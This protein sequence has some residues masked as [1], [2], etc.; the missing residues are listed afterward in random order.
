M[1]TR[2]EHVEADAKIDAPIGHRSVH[3]VCAVYCPHC[4]HPFDG[5]LHWGHGNI[6]DAKCGNCD[7]WFKVEQEGSTE[8]WASTWM[9]R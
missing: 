5:R 1:D 8:F 6:A 3:G 7:K 2:S 4:L 9:E